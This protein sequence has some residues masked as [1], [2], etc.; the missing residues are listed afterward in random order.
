MNRWQIMRSFYLVLFVLSLS[1]SHCTP[2]QEGHHYVYVVNCSEEEIIY[3]ATVGGDFDD[4]KI[5]IECPPSGIIIF[6]MD[7][8]IVSKD[9]ACLETPHPDKSWEEYLGKGKM[10]I[11]VVD[12][13]TYSLVAESSGFD[14]DSIQ[15]Y[16]P[17]LY[18]Y[19][20]TL[21]DLQRM[22]WTVTYPPI[23]QCQ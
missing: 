18:S 19:T 8:Q 3:A 23:G 12:S 2:I 6:P 1:A 15:K 22:N 13:E 16:V 17:I 10:R 5:E 21:E 9:T 20:L 11:I 7:L 14:C 4:D